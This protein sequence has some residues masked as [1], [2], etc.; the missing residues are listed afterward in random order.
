MPFRALCVPEG[1]SNLVTD[2]TKCLRQPQER[3]PWTVQGWALR[4]AM[5]ERLVNSC[6]LLAVSTQPSVASK[7]NADG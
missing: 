5:M 1:E 7:L 3:S 4:R 6:Q 2:V